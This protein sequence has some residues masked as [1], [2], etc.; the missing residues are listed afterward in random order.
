MN[1]CM[2]S[3]WIKGYDRVISTVGSLYTVKGHVHLIKVFPELQ[4]A[5]STHGRSW[6]PPR[7]REVLFSRDGRQV[8]D[9]L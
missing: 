1:N 6:S 5:G 9:L 7:A 2:Q 3:V 8:S 4:G